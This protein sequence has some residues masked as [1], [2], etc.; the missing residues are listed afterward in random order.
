MIKRLPYCILLFLFSASV[1]L[2]QTG[3]IR[4][5]VKTADGRP[6]DLVSIAVKG[7]AKGSLTNKNGI[8][9]IKNIPAGPRIIIATFIGLEKQEQAVEVKAHDTVTVNFV[10]KENDSELQEVIISTKKSKKINTIVAKMPLKNLENAQV[11]NTVSSETIKQQG[12]T[13]FDDALRN[14]PGIARTWESSGRA[15]DGA[16][17]FAL[18]GFNAQPS[19]INGLPGITTGSLDLADV[20]EIQVIKGPSATLF[21]GTF[22]GYGGIINTI[23]KKPYFTTGGEVTYNVGSFGLNRVAADFNTPLSKTE[24]VALDR[25]SVV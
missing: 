23:T 13:T 22:A 2:A 7:T 11:Y 10:L 14:V 25:K 21:G 9:Q 6:A 15:Q 5:S 8:F 17:N 19:L 4:G 1:A 18:R 3:S 12:I 16:A 20:E 24:K